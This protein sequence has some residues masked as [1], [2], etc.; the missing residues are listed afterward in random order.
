MTAAKAL[1]DKVSGDLIEIRDL[2]N[3][4]GIIG[5]IKA[6]MDA[7]GAKTTRIEPNT[8]NTDNYDRIY[9]GTPIWAGKPAPAINTVINNG[10]IKGKE[11]VIFVTLGGI[12]T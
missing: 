3:R 4:R 10:E 7:R 5:W 12:K 11:I 2:K 8:I 9:I 6:A 1:A